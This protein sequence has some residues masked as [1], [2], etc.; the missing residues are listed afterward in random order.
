MKKRYETPKIDVI[1]IMLEGN[2]ATNFPIYSKEGNETLS[3]EN[4]NMEFGED[5]K[6]ETTK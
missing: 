4:P 3:K 5:F 2:V 6:E 1:Q